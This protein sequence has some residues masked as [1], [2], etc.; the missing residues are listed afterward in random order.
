MKLHI[1]YRQKETKS[2]KEHRLRAEWRERS[3]RWSFWFCLWPRRLVKDNDD[4]VF[5]HTNT[6]AWLEYV[7]IRSR[8]RDGTAPWLFADQ[9]YVLTQPGEKK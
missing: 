3:R 1:T 4:G 5:V 7:A 2:E 6:V 9:S 8:D